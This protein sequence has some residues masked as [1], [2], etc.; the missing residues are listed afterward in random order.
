LAKG[1]AASDRLEAAKG[2]GFSAGSRAATDALVGLLRDKQW[3]VRGA[4]ADSLKSL[5]DV[6]AVPALTHAL[7]METNEGVRESIRA[8]LE[9]LKRSSDYSLGGFTDP[10]PA[11]RKK[12]A[13]DALMR[14]DGRT[15]E[16][17]I[18]LLNDPVAEVRAAA[19]ATLV[20]ERNPAVIAFEI[21]T[22]EKDDDVIARMNAAEALGELHAVEAVEPLI[23]ALSDSSGAV[24][25]KAIVALGE[26]GDPRAAR[27]IAGTITSYSFSNWYEASRALSKLGDA[28]LTALLALLGNGEEPVRMAAARGL[29]LF[30]DPRATAALIKAL[31][32]SSDIV[33]GDAAGSLGQ[34]G[35]RSA[36]EPLLD[37]LRRR[38]GRS[39]EAVAAALGRL[40]DQRAVPALLA[41]LRNPVSAQE[42]T[43]IITALGNLGGADSLDA[44]IQII[45]GRY[46]SKHI[47]EDL[48]RQYAAE[49]IGNIGGGRADSVL[50]NALRKQDL[51][52]IQ[53]AA[54]YF[55]AMGREESEA[56]LAQ[57]LNSQDGRLRSLAQLY[58]VSGNPSLVAAARAWAE[59]QHVTISPES[60]KPVKW[61]QGSLPTK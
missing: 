49:S 16:A 4:A 44:L 57:A 15:V 23:R 52:A 55:I 34:I 41:E 21:R 46:A 29:Q 12:S 3:F 39:N 19:A 28:G 40:R 58:L 53:G 18:G 31:N 25:E 20:E 43:I 17:L 13:R 37:A 36:I 35:D 50:F 51:P 33:R 27:P 22:L 54:R 61:K 59:A 11:V 2:L 10:D 24:R 7:E 6:S 1:E 60:Y 8:A 26:I 14:R 48:E 5:G 9:T 56:L 32:D 38:G 47:F 30:K 42:A 45:Q